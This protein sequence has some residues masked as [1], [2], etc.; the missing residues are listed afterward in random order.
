VI[1]LGLGTAQWGSPYGVSNTAGVPADTEIRQILSAAGGYGL[2]IIDT[3]SQYGFSEETLGR[4]LPDA[5]HFRIVTKTPALKTTRVTIDDVQRMKAAFQQ[6]LQRLRRESI[7]GLLIHH[8]ADL[9]ADP[10]G[11]LWQALQDLRRQKLVEKIGVSVYT[12]LEIDAMIGQVRPDIIQVP[13]NVLDQRLA[14]SGHLTRLKEMGI[15]VHARSIFLQGLLLMDVDHLPAYFNPWVPLLREFLGDVRR[16]GMTP[17]QSAL[18][19]VLARPEIDSVLVGVPSWRE[20]EAIMTAAR[21]LPTGA[22]HDWTRWAV[23]DERLLNP[24]F[25]KV[26]AA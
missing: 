8:P 2:S 25:W 10:D 19:A 6:S 4:C 13:Y 23:S 26:S 21:A 16:R 3:A 1:K 12:G 7:Y 18:H 5:S 17:L 15:E 9:A 14:Q 20:F 22:T 24:S 11:L